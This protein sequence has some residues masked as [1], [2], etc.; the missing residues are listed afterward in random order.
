[1]TTNALTKKTSDDHNRVHASAVTQ[2][3][4]AQTTRSRRGTDAADQAAAH[5][6]TVSARG[7]ALYIGLS[8]ELAAANDTTLRLVAEAL[9]KTLKEIVPE[10]ASHAV[11]ALAPKT[12]KGSDVDL[13]RIALGEP[14]YTSRRKQQQLRRKSLKTT[15]VVVDFSR[16]HVFIDDEK[17]A[18]TYREF[19]LLKYL[20]LREGLNVSREELVSGLWAD[21]DEIPNART[22]DVHIRRLRVK[23]GLYE[24]I[25]QTVRGKGYR[26]DGHVD[27]SVIAPSGPS[28]EG[29]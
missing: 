27:V 2:V 10:A 6:N 24:D 29:F 9:N 19:A 7:F 17:V 3:T 18:L 28:P 1:M 22:V 5:L 15:A 11:V 14:E 25:I 16:N 13:V 20:V 21:S 23:L 12:A 8:E 4:S 26:F